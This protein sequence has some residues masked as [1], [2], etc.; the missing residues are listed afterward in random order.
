MACLEKPGQT[1]RSASPYHCEGDKSK[2]L[3]IASSTESESAVKE[4]QILKEHG[5]E[6]F[7]DGKSE[8]PSNSL[9]TLISLPKGGQSPLY[10]FRQRRNQLRASPSSEIQNWSNPCIQRGP[11]N[12]ASINCATSGLITCRQS[13]P[14]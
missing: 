12:I 3:K 5:L 1:P 2:K 7:K 10:L 6:L 9:S 4:G 13:W 8:K 14:G 11:I